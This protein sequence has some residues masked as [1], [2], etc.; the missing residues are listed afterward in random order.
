MIELSIHLN[1]AAF[2]FFIQFKLK[3]KFIL[4]RGCKVLC[5]V[6]MMMEDINYI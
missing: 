2:D 4:P 1:I 3:C 5:R 6:D